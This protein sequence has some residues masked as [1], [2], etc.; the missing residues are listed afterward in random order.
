VQ[1][2]IFMNHDDPETIVMTIRPG[3]QITQTCF[4][5]GARH[6]EL[7]SLSELSTRHSAH[8]P[9]TKHAAL[10]ALGGAV[11]LAALWELM[12]PAGRML[13]GVVLFGLVLLTLISSRLRPRRLELWAMRHGRPTLLLASDDWWVFAAVERQ[14]HRSINESRLGMM[15]APRYAAP[16]SAV[17]H[18]SAMHPSKIH[19]ANS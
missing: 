10:F 19:P 18:P 7:N 1:W 4:Q 3:L 15:A 14:L 6:Y 8:D 17:P 13:T 12:Q 5:V 9:L 16:E 11:T 2:E